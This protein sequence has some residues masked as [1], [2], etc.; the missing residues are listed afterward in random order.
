[1][2]FADIMEMLRNPQA[3]QARVEELRARTARVQATGSSGGGMVK[4]TLN[5]AMDMLGCEIAPEAVDPREAVLLQDLVRAAYNDAA[6]KVKEALQAEL[7]EGAGGLPFPPGF[8]G[9]A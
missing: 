8:P 6:A 1:M 9:S 2:N 3:L 4:V 7:A 5:G